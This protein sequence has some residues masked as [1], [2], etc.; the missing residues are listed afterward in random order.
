MYSRT[1]ARCHLR[2]HLRCHVRGHLRSV[3][4]H[5]VETILADG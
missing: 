5:R 3:P 4:F 2:C 1:Q